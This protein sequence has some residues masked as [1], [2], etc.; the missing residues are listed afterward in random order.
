M[1]GF[2]VRSRFHN[3]KYHAEFGPSFLCRSNT[4]TALHSLTR[5]LKL[6]DPLRQMIACL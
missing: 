4:S 1:V 2:S 6:E 5:L 3:L